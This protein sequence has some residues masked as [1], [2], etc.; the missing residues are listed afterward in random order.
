MMKQ[1]SKLV[2]EQFSLPL[3]GDLRNFKS[4]R[5]AVVGKKLACRTEGFS[6]GDL[7]FNNFRVSHKVKNK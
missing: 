5:T 4:I 6:T 3:H 7:G 2:Q 1:R